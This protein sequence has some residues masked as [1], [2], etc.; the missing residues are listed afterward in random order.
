MT[1]LYLFN[2]LCVISLFT[3]T[4]IL[5]EFRCKNC[6][7]RLV[8]HLYH[9]G[10]LAQQYEIGESFASWSGCWESFRFD[11]SI[12][13]LRYRFAG[14]KIVTQVQLKMINI[15]HLVDTMTFHVHH[16]VPFSTFGGNLNMERHLQ[17]RRSK[18]WYTCS[19]HRRRILNF[20]DKNIQLPT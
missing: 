13:H 16:M 5:S 9:G 19:T 15:T 7:M 18:L 1:G 14:Q 6:G 4:L 11:I 3:R 2:F 12:R 17:A 8:G 20:P 10:K